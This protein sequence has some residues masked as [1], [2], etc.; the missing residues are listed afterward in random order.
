M[1]G[2]ERLSLRDADP[3]AYRAMG[4]LSRYVHEGPLEPGLLALVDIRASQINGCAWC[5]DMHSAEARDAGIDQR[6]LD[7]IPAW[8]ETGDLFT[9]REQAAIAFA[10]EVTLISDGGVSDEVWDMVRAEFDDKEIV[11]LVMAVGA[12]NVWNRMNISMRTPIGPEP[13][14]IPADQ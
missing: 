3:E 1:S 10:E 13:Y 12:I 4:G 7:L 6:K 5:L 14:R 2:E 9:A 8:H 11:S